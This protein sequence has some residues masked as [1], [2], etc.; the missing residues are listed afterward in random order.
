MNEQ[1]TV[2]LDVSRPLDGE[3]V[4]I[5]N[6]SVRSRLTFELPGGVEAGESVTRAYAIR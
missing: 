2:H 1:A 5:L 6:G 4:E 3:S